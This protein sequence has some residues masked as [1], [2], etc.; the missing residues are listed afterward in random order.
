MRIA[1]VAVSTFAALVWFTGALFLAAVP[2]ATAAASGP[3]KVTA[4]LSLKKQVF[5]T[6]GATSPPKNVKLANKG[7]DVIALLDVAV[8][9]DFAVDPAASTC[10]ASLAPKEKCVLAVTFTPTALGERLGQLTITHSA[11]GSPQTVV[12]KGKGFAGKLT[13]APKS[14][15]FSDRAV[16]D[17][18]PAKSIVLHNPNLV[19]VP[20]TGFGLDVPDFAIASRTC[21]SSLLPGAD[22]T[23]T[24]RFVPGAEGGRKGTLRIAAL[25]K[26]NPTA[27]KLKGKGL[28]ATCGGVESDVLTNPANCG[29]CGNACPGTCV[30]GQCQ[31]GTVSCGVGT[32]DVCACGSTTVCTDFRDDPAN[33]GQ[34]GNVCFVGQVCE[35]GSC[36]GCTSV[37]APDQCGSVCTSFQGDPFHCGGCGV[38]CASGLCVAGKCLA[39]TEDAPEECGG[40]CTK[41]LTDAANCGG[42]GNICPAGVPCQDGQCAGIVCG[43]ET[44]QQCGS[45]C[46]NLQT[47]A[48]NCGACGT[49]C[50]GGS[51]VEGACVVCSD[52]VPDQCGS[53]CTNFSVD[54]ANCGGC[55]NLCPAGSTCSGGTCVASAC[56]QIENQQ[57][58][59]A[60]TDAEVLRAGSKEP[61]TN[62]GAIRCG[63]DCVDLKTSQFNC[64]QCFKACSHACVAGQ[65]LDCK[66]ETPDACGNACTNFKTSAQNCGGCGPEFECKGGGKLCL[67]GICQSPDICDGKPTNTNISQQ[68]CGGCNQPCEAA[69]EVCRA[70]ECARLCEDSDDISCR[71]MCVF[72]FTDEF[73]GG[74][75]NDCIKQ[76]LTCVTPHGGDEDDH[77]ICS[78]CTDDKPD[79]CGA[80]CTNLNTDLANC[81]ACGKPCENGKC[82][83]VGCFPCPANVP[84]LC[85]NECVDLRRDSFH[86]GACE[87]N[88]GGRA[89]CFERHCIECPDSAPTVCFR[90]GNACVNTA[91]D[92]RNCGECFHG[93]LSDQKC[94]D[95]TCKDCNAT[96]NPCV[97]CADPKTRCG[98]ECVDTRTEA[99][100]CGGCGNVC[101]SGSCVQGQCAPGFC[102]RFEVTAWDGTVTEETSGNICGGAATLS[103]D[104]SLHNLLTFTPSA[105]Q[106]GG[107]DVSGALRLN[108]AGAICGQWAG[109]WTCGGTVGPTGSLA[110]TCNCLTAMPAGG[111]FA[112]DVYSGSW[113]FSKSGTDADGEAVVDTASGGFTLNRAP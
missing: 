88:C 42:C 2:D 79:K 3:L 53:T 57:L 27:I 22:C 18:G 41:L 64:G 113:T 60:A 83:H 86:C 61:C 99:G 98:N 34:C 87:K 17:S 62:P 24:L 30:Q 32:P 84:D 81:G 65:C 77:V 39:C 46:T 69:K 55:G 37:G 110:L 90:D 48:S 6:V 109:I 52:S 108:Q 58:A 12:L 10:A 80:Q 72:P 67:G 16:G 47:D 21:G 104:D 38:P 44:P 40:V 74:C 14:V 5:G 4:K 91:I 85:G 28:P 9:G 13:V 106:T 63:D 33:C 1:P 26:K 49:V 51:C 66:G 76:G 95:G 23:I 97:D 75:D 111:G 25:T 93:C 101:P 78:S 103:L 36:E 7:P 35:H 102:G 43:A 31:G 70:G 54:A 8:Q 82:D 45:R 94:V 112:A 15:K 20:I 19:P 11:A 105:I 73:C 59:R 68:H 56:A 89:Y 100:N 96:D 29:G 92:P 71:G 50:A 107:C